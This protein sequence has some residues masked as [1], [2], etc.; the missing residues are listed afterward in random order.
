MTTSTAIAVLLVA[1]VAPLLWTS[2]FVLFAWVA[3]QRYARLR[4]RPTPP[5]P[6]LQTLTVLWHE[7]TALLHVQSWRITPERGTHTLDSAEHPVLCVHGFTQNASNWRRVRQA[8]HEQGRQTDAVSLGY[9]PRAVDRYVTAL[10]GR[11]DA[12]VARTEGPVDV[13]AHS[14][15]GV[16]LRLLLVRR[17]DLAARLGRIVTVA[18]P[19]RGTAATGGWLLP[20]TRLLR[21]GNPALHSLPMLGELAPE[22]TVV[23]IGSLDDTTVYPEHSTH[24]GATH[25]T[26]EGLGHAGLIVSPA[27]VARI[28]AALQS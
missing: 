20:E 13:V 22:A 4:S 3:R 7:V 15:G 5:R 6:L 19:H 25:H 17:P 21:R 23:S 1:L 9:P 2:V 11:L 18:T 24:G 8:L 10:E 28:V 26:L 16:I 14:M 12:L 27:G